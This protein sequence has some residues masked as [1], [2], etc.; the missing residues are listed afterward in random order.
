MLVCFQR[1]INLVVMKR[2]LTRLTWLR[3]RPLVVLVLMTLVTTCNSGAVQ[4]DSSNIDGAIKDNKFVFVNFY[5]D[6]CRFSTASLGLGPDS[7]S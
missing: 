7:T 1:G 6:W 2:D 5:V 3:V 4:L